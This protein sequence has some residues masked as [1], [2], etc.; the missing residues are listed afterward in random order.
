MKLK[1]VLAR[2]S[3]SGPHFGE[4]FEGEPDQ[5]A[6]NALSR[7][8]K[9]V[10]D[11]NRVF[12]LVCVGMVLAIFGGACTVAVRC[13]ADPTFV[14]EVFAATGVSLTGLVLQM[15]KLWKEK[16]RSDMVL[17]LARSLSPQDIR[18]ILEVLLKS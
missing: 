10:S 1:D 17:V 15:L 12:F 8:L 4:K 5:D 14:K 9:A 6:A 18:G 3:E 16:V 13:I 2:Y 7:D 11:Q